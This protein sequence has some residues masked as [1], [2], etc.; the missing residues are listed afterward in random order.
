MR[1]YCV[2][3]RVCES[4]AQVPLSL[5]AAAPAGTVVEDAEV[6]VSWCGSH[7]P[8]LPTALVVLPSLTLFLLHRL[9][10]NPLTPAVDP[11]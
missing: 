4:I 7:Y 6:A 11:K 10:S 5:F 3:Y 8:S 1:Y 2:V 9:Y